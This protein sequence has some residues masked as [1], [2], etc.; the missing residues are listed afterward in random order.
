MNRADRPVGDIARVTVVESAGCHFCAEASRELAVFAQ[1]YPLEISSID[2]QTAPGRQLV[3]SHRAAMSPL[4][5]LDGEYFSSGRLPRR[6]LA[7]RLAQRFGNHA[8]SRAV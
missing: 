1:R 5:L 7:A 2:I 4:V 8:P 6:K 3:Q